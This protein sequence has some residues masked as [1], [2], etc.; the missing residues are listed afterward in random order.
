MGRTTRIALIILLAS[1]TGLQAWSQVRLG[2]EGQ[3]SSQI[4]IAVPP[5][6]AA[7][8]LETVANEMTQSLKFDLAFTGL[9][10]MTPEASFPATFKGY[11]NDAA[12]I[13]FVAWRTTKA[14]YLVYAYVTEENGVLAAQ[15][16]LFDMMTGSQV[17][18]QQLTAERKYPRLIAH[19]F[20]EEI[21]RLLD[22][23]PGIASSEIC[24]SGGGSGKKEIYV[25]DYDGANVVQITKHGSISIKPKLSP[26]GRLVAYLSY[27][28]RYPFLYILDRS[29]G[30]STPLSKNVG[31]N[32]APAW[33]PD[34]KRLAFT[35]SKDAN[36]EIYIKNDDGS[37]LIRVTNDRASD[38]SPSFN[39]ANANEL[40]FVSDRSG[41]PQIF[42]VN[43]DGSNVRRLS[44]QGGSSY[45]PVWSPDGKSIAYVAEK[46]GDGLEIYVMDADGKNPRRLTQSQGSNESPTWSSDSRHVAFTTSRGGRSELWGVTVAT[47]VETRLSSTNLECQGPYWGPRRN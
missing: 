19:R 27:K 24:F 7:P 11:T 44:Y 8:G 9:I 43:V 4:P 42:A 17:I 31:L 46:P 15:C 18:G 25:S 29:T 16:R 26:D 47:G 2:S 35:L 1:I 10:S 37:G 14:E 6:G 21:I 38:T 40:A 36:T 28:D 13:D 23:V 3:V 34:G 5:F 12:T 39:P 30:K 20:S 41:R 22:G 32:A 33:A 45:D